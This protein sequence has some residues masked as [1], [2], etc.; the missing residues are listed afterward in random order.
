MNQIYGLR[1]QKIESPQAYTLIPV[2]DQEEPNSRSSDLSEGVR[3]HSNGH[4]NDNDEPGGNRTGWSGNVNALGVAD[5]GG[6][7]DDDAFDPSPFSWLEYLSFFWV[8]VS[9]MWTWYVC[10]PLDVL[11]LHDY[12]N[13]SSTLYY[14]HHVPVEKSN[15]PM[16]THLTPSPGP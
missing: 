1:P 15:M 13:L 6:T 5:G 7:N 3:Q 12:R 2:Q 14:F 9:M 10:S 16:P 11:L 8:G 4:G